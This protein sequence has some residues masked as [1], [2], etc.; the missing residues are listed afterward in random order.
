MSLS[1]VHDYG[2]GPGEFELAGECSSL[3]ASS[4]HNF[5]TF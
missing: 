3:F 2:L 5:F 4:S 1:E